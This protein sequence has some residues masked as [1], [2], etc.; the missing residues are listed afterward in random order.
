VHNFE[1]SE[2]M[3]FSFSKVVPLRNILEVFSERHI[4]SSFFFVVDFDVLL[5]NYISQFKCWLKQDILFLKPS[6][7]IK[8]STTFHFRHTGR[9][10]INQAQLLKWTT[11]KEQGFSVSVSF[12]I[13][14]TSHGHFMTVYLLI[15]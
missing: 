2:K 3:K 13:C 14:I 4:L 1:N 15:P 12:T 8:F 9:G 6:V 10:N 7:C 5:I 11:W